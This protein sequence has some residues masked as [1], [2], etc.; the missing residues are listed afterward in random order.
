M[1]SRDYFIWRLKNGLGDMAL[2]ETLSIGTSA[3]QSGHGH[4][5]STLAGAGFLIRQSERA[6][7]RSLQIKK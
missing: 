3:F 4:L 2:L 6:P 1:H 5:Q 7:S